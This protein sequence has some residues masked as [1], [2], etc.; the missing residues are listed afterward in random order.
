MPW[1]HGDQWVTR[2][3]DA[4]GINRKVPLPEARTR[5]EAK[6]HEAELR[7]KGWRQREGLEP[8]PVDR[9]FTVGALLGWWLE[10]YV[11]G[12]PSEGRERSR[13]RVHFEGSDLVR[14]PAAALTPGRLEAFLQE[15]VQGGMA[16]ASVNHLRSMVRA[17]WNCARKAEKLHG[18]NPATDVAR[19]K[20]P[21]RKPSFLEAHEVP[22]VLA[23]LGT[24][25][26]DLVAVAVYAGLRKGELFGL[27]KRDVD[28]ERGLLMVGRSYDR[29]TT[30]G[31]SEEPVPIS[32]DLVPYLEHALSAA[33]GEL[34]FPKPDGTHRTEEDKLGD[35]L[36]GAMNRANIVDGWLHV[37]RWWKLHPKPAKYEERHPDNERRR[38]TVCQ[39][40]LFPKAI[41]RRFRLHDTRHT[42]ATLMLAAGVDLYAVAKILRH[43]DPRVTFETYSHLVP[44]Y[45]RDQIDKVSLG[46]SL[47]APV[48]APPMRSSRGAYVPK[49]QGRK[50]DGTLLAPSEKGLM[51]LSSVL[52]LEAGFRESSSSIGSAE[53]AGLAPGLPQR[54]ASGIDHPAEGLSEDDCYRGD[55]LAG[56]VGFEPT[57][58]GFVVRR[59]IQLS[60]GPFDCC[61]DGVGGEAGIRTLDT[62]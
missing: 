41:P 26:R 16:P 45:L 5:E 53:F 29:E 20:V 59:S 18:D 27:R 40:M 49:V 4:A 32:R 3:K 56:P 60:Y 10:T 30:K 33:P 58:F 6:R 22:L 37:C 34:L 50:I 54:A 17:A 11:K 55:K 61:C 47:A 9:S 13:W 51:S 38:C 42:A 1:K 2:V 46:A 14:L 7:L 25:D 35:R 48:E 28:L 24:T 19:R 23:Q 62:V 36:R 21:K 15:K 8:L 12:G 31:K 57:A 43:K 52:S 39:R 44:G